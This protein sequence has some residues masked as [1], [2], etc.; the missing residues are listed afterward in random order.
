MGGISASQCNVNLVEI[1]KVRRGCEREREKAVTWISLCPSALPVRHYQRAVAL[2]RRAWAH[3][4]LEIIKLQLLG[5]TLVEW[6]AGHISSV[7]AI[8]SAIKGGHKNLQSPKVCQA[9]HM[10]MDGWWVGP[11]LIVCRK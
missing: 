5:D 11:D 9:L 10:D 8:S 2:T 1:N 7:H 3:W 6:H 4:L